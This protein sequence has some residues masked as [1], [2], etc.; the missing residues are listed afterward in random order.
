M[1]AQ[2]LL[3][4]NPLRYHDNQESEDS[5]EVIAPVLFENRP[6]HCDDMEVVAQSMQAEFSGF[7]DNT[8][9][10][11]LYFAKSTPLFSPPAIS[12]ATPTD[13]QTV[14]TKY[15]EA[16]L[17]E[18]KLQDPVPRSWQLA[19]A[20]LDRDEQKLVDVPK[21]SMHLFDADSGEITVVPECEQDPHSLVTHRNKIRFCMLN[22]DAPESMEWHRK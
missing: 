12:Q 13:V 8:M 1:P 20:Y 19:G 7:S 5:K 2:N 15:M 6:I 18:R 4:L 17:Q 3:S 22:C 9:L 16:F 11:C 14:T 21:A 10:K